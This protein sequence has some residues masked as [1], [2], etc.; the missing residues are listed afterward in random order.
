MSATIVEIPLNSPMDVRPGNPSGQTD[1]FFSK[2]FAT[3]NPTGSNR[4]N[5]VCESDVVFPRPAMR[6]L[7]SYNTTGRGMIVDRLNAVYAIQGN[8]FQSA[9]GIVFGTVDN[10]TDVTSMAV[11]PFGTTYI[12]ITTAAAGYYYNGAAVTPVTDATF[13]G[14]TRVPGL[15]YLDGTFYVMD[16][17]SAIYG[18][19]NLNDFSVWDPLNRINAWQASDYPIG[20]L[21]HRQYVLA[22]KT[23]CTQ[24]FYDAGNVT[25]S[26]LLP[27]QQMYIPFGCADWDSVQSINKDHIWVSRSEEGVY[28]VVRISNAQASVVSTP[29]VDRILTRAMNTAG[30]F[31]GSWVHAAYGHRWYGLNFSDPNGSASLVFDMTTNDWSFWTDDKGQGFDFVSSTHVSGYS[32]LQSKTKGIFEDSSIYFGTAPMRDQ[33]VSGIYTGIP[34][35][36]QT[37]P[38]DGGMLVEKTAMRLEILSDNQGN[39]NLMVCWSDDDYRT[40]SSWRTINITEP[41]SFLDDL[42]TFRR[43]AFRFRHDTAL[44]LRIQKALLHILPGA[45]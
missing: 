3:K 38:F 23:T 2:I 40:W 20:I 25:G 6:I 33:L 28:C 29:S 41:R 7:Y 8:S 26:P 39:G 30:G 4:L 1:G 15:A 27:L 42:G 24:V 22:L 5:V 14:L 13:T 17:S 35:E 36:I 34:F 11:V 45:A 16:T 19:K 32:Y 44:P 43:R 10:G 37:P 21:T 18:S 9:S 12:A 31:T